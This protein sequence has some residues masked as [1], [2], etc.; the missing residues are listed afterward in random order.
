MRMWTVQ[1]YMGLRNNSLLFESSPNS[2]TCPATFPFQDA[3]VQGSGSNMAGL[4][5]DT[6]L[7]RLW[8]QF[9]Q[10]G[11]RRFEVPHWNGARHGWEMA[12]WGNLEHGNTTGQT[13]GGFKA[14]RFHFFPVTVGGEGRSQGFR[15]GGICLS[16]Q[17]VISFEICL[18]T[19]TLNDE[20]DRK[21]LILP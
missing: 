16:K 9:G 19:S 5:N 6:A 3:G 1:L 13:G 21:G 14:M 4:S 15:S 8:R 18:I 2:K 10:G 11:A 17:S 7:L 12:T 20:E